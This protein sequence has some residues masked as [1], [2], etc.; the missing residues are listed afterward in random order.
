[1][2]APVQYFPRTAPPPRET[3][4]RPRL[5]TLLLEENLPPMGRFAAARPTVPTRFEARVRHT[6]LIS[7]H[8]QT[9][10][11]QFSL[12]DPLIYPSG[13][14]ITYTAM[15]TSEE[16]TSVTACLDV[17]V[18]LI[19]VTELIVRKK[20]EE[21]RR[22]IATGIN[23][24]RQDGIHELRSPDHRRTVTDAQNIRQ[25][26]SVVIKGACIAGGQGEE[27]SWQVNGTAAV[28]VSP[29]NTIATCFYSREL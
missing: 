23:A 20:K 21:I 11:Y 19:Q 1:M 28:K 24:E 14:T 6:T 7:Y 17:E 16:H 9:H 2:E 8:L 29:A 25:G 4:R 22:L 10:F 27:M 13:T 5:R 26:G 15:L 12:E 18:Q 3:G